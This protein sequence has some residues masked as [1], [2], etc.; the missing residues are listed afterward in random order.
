MRRAARKDDN[1]REIEDAFRACGFAVHDTSRLGDGFPDLAVYRPANG[2]V[3]VE[4]KDGSK[5]PSARKLTR[6]EEA[7]SKRFPVR[8]VE[9]VEDVLSLAGQ[10]DIPRRDL[11]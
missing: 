11:A 2:I 5:P 6:A 4:V 1:Q 8:L 10:F 3:L 9:S 7:F